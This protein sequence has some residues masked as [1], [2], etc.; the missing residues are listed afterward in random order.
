L[1]ICLVVIVAALAVI[2][3]LRP[4][5]PGIVIENP[6]RAQWAIAVTPPAQCRPFPSTTPTTTAATQ[7]SP[8]AH[9]ESFPS[10]RSQ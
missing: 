8:D 1:A 2:V 3:L 9:G 4:A 5:R 10:L 6:R 7:D